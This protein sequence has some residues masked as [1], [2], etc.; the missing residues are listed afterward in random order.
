MRRSVLA[1]FFLCSTFAF[2][3]TTEITSPR[4]TELLSK[5]ESMKEHDRGKVYSEIARELVELAN[6]QFN[7]GELDK[8]MGSIRQ[9]VDYAEKA[10][11]VARE[12][13][14][15]IKDTEINLRKCT[16]R[17]DEVR[18]TLALDDQPPL[19]AAHQR[20]EQLNKELLLYMF[21]EK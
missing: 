11:R 16:R 3:A 1:I 13:S 5:A 19:V 9:A 15:K 14:K 7:Q 6:A 18:R 8:G 17:L 2:A 12:K 10:A 4:L 20:L 21:A